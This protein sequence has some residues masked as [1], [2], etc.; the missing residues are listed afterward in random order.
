MTAPSCATCTH[1]HER[2]RRKAVRTLDADGAP[3]IVAP[4]R[5]YPPAVAAAKTGVRWPLTARDEGCGEWRE[6]GLRFPDGTRTA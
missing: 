2:E 6:R 1:W 3:L 4:C 5:R